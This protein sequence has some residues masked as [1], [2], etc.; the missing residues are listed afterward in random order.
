M[1]N[2]SRCQV[3]LDGGLTWVNAGNGV[4]VVI[5]EINETEDEFED[6]YLTVSD[7]GLILDQIGQVSGYCSG[8]AALDLDGLVAL[9]TG[10]DGEK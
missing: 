7:E 3:S 6:M 10:K 4:R 1:T 9:T 2:V 5:R 8:T